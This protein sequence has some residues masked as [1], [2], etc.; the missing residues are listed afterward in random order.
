MAAMKTVTVLIICAVM[1]SLN[2]LR[3][4]MTVMVAVQLVRAQ[5]VEAMQRFKL[6]LKPVTMA[7]LM[8]AEV[9]MRIVRARARAQPVVMAINAPKPSSAMT[10]QRTAVVAVML[11]V[12][13]LA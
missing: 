6:S 9:V 5:E 2:A 12:A 13:L 11:I 1:E 4:V 8:L 3:P 7:M 10:V